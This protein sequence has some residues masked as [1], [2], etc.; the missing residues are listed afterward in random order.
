MT[1]SPP[2]VLL[3]DDGELEDVA[4]VLVELGVPFDRPREAD[5]APDQPPAQDLL[6]VT[7]SRARALGEPTDTERPSLP[8]RI[9]VCGD[10]NAG[11]DQLRRDVLRKLGF[12][13]LVRGPAQPAVWRLLIEHYLERA[14]A[15]ETQHAAG[16]LEGGLAGPARRANLV[17]ICT[18][19]C[20]ITAEHELRTADRV[21]VKI[22]A[23]AGSE[24]LRL[25]GTLVRI[26]AEAAASEAKLHAAAVLFDPELPAESREGLASLLNAWT[27]PESLLPEGARQWATPLP[28]CE[29]PTIEGLT[30]DDDTDPPISPR[31]SV[32]VTVVPLPFEPG[33]TERRSRPRRSFAGGVLAL[34]KSYR[35]G[36]YARTLLGRDL[37]S[38][39]MRVE[40]LPDLELGDRL[41]IALHRP[42]GEPIT[43]DARV[44]RDDGKDGLAL[45][46]ENVEP[47]QAR[48]L[49]RMVA[50][51]PELESLEEGNPAPGAIV[52]EIL[53]D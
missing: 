5:Y 37:S 2:R 17:D 35:A 48:E 25:V 34:P 28:A 23:V 19:G 6:L 3:L 38:G 30:F 42:E 10:R 41:R 40:G 15:H 47:A 21:A 53:P 8:F 33:G 49:E 16:A 26:A 43:V 4:S 7:T 29:S 27:K 22:P 14:D 31:H 45:G 36:T 1:P 12:Q 20:R 46:F 13:L 39:G 50:G 11:R 51:L 9:V 24:T 44:V 32:E 18:R 52:S